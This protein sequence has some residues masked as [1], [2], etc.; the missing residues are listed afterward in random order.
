[1]RRKPPNGRYLWET[2]V[3]YLGGALLFLAGLSL[4]AISLRAH[5]TGGIKT[6]LETQGTL[7]VPGGLAIIALAAK[8]AKMGRELEALK[9][10]NGEEK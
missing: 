6:L 4:L 5:V 1:M 10:K 9:K 2:V 3:T 7:A 8:Q